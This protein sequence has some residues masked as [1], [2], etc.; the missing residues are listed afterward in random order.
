MH[1]DYN[2]RLKF[3]ENYQVLI[4]SPEFSMSQYYCFLNFMG[5]TLIHNTKDS[6]K[7]I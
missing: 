1:C 2:C 3:Y 6:D 5:E 7:Q 4:N